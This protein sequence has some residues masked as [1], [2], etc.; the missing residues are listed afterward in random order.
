MKSYKNVATVL[1]VTP[2]T[3]DTIANEPTTVEKHVERLLGGIQ[4][5]NLAEAA[6]ATECSAELIRRFWRAMGFPDIVNPESKLFTEYDVDVMKKHLQ[7]YGD[8]LTDEDTLNSLI[9][10]QSHLLERLILWQY[11]ALVEE[12]EGR[13]NI[14]DVSAR[15]MFLDKI[16]E[17]DDFLMYQMKYAWRRHMTALLRRTETE[18]DNQME[19]GDG[20]MPLMRALGFVDLVS[21]TRRSGELSPHALVDFIQTFEFTCRDVVSMHGARVVKMVGDAVFYIADDLETGIAVVNHIVE[22]LQEIPDMPDVR[23]SLVWGRVLS[24][25]GDVFGPNA[26]LAARLCSVAPVNGI[27]ADQSTAE[28]LKALDANKYQT[29]YYEVPELHG[30]G[31]IRAEQVTVKVSE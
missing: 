30:I 7:M 10:A 16:A 25:F 1:F 31:S 12:F 17:Y 11:E 24:R 13:Y 22:A 26:N 27:L 2:N 20:Q 5:Y 3:S 9:R 8:K 6:E 29:E 23:A 14:D 21:F 4:K 15:Y 18:L 19:N 28:K